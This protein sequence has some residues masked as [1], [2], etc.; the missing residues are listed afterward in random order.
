MGVSNFN[1]ERVKRAAKKFKERGVPFASNQIQYS[2]AYRA[3]ETDTGVIDAC[4]GRGVTP[5]AYSPMAQGLLTGKYSAASPLGE[6][7]K[8]TGPR[9][10]ILS[11]EKLASADA[12]VDLMRR[13]GVTTAAP[14]PRRSR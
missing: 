9:A 3:P 6:G 1:A 14:P 11:E 12:L 4:V 8:A 13:S 2:L 5:V 10:R 7:V